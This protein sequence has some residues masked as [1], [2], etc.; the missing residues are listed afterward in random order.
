MRV[1]VQQKAPT[2][3][4]NMNKTKHY[5]R[6]DYLVPELSLRLRESGK[7]LGT[8]SASLGVVMFIS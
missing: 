3:Y 8:S 2:L 4:L 6:R 7:L 5:R 1:E